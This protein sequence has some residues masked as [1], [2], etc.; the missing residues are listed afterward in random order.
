MDFGVTNNPQL[1]LSKQRILD[2]GRWSLSTGGGILS[3]LG[4]N[5]TYLAKVLKANADKLEFTGAHASEIG[6]CT[7]QKE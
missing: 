2:P 7:I 5:A 4:I 3:L 1:D 6:R